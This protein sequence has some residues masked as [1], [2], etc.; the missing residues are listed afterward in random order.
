MS[1]LGRHDE[2]LTAIIHGEV[3]GVGYRFFAQRQAAALGLRGYVRNQRDGTVE[4]V[5]EGARAQLSLLLETLRSGP[6]AADV[7]G[8]DAK[9]SVADG[10]F[11]GFH[12]RT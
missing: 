8:V 5:A 9:W 3:H 6:S 11:S 12:V 4:V 1:S 10:T 2:R 7:T